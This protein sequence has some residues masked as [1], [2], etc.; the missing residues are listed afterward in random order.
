MLRSPTNYSSGSWEPLATPSSHY[1][2]DESQGKL[3]GLGLG[4]WPLSHTALFFPS[5]AILFFL[6]FSLTYTRSHTGYFWSLRGWWTRPPPGSGRFQDWL[7]TKA[8]NRTYS[9][10]VHRAA[11]GACCSDTRSESCVADTAAL[12]SPQSAS[13]TPLYCKV[14]TQNWHQHNL[15]LH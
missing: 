13:D 2:E 5:G 15:H 12:W 8:N 3:A 7:V 1:E 10:G 6:L 9:Q 4:K 11:S 14:E